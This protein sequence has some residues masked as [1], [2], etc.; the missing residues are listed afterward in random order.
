MK[1]FIMTGKSVALVKW[2]IN[3]GDNGDK[4]HFFGADSPA[5]SFRFLY[6]EKKIEKKWKWLYIEW[7]K[8]H[9]S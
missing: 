4:V 7:F 3:Q 6:S 1:L 8:Y 2:E 5:S 9:T